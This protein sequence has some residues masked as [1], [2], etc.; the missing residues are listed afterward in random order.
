MTLFRSS[1]FALTEYGGGSG[2]CRKREPAR[3]GSACPVRR[4]GVANLRCTL[5][6]DAMR[7]V[8]LAAF[9]TFAFVS[10][11]SAQERWSGFYLGGHGGYGWGNSSTSSD[12]DVFNEDVFS[13]GAGSISSDP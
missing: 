9:V 7:R 11:A 5:A 3:N 1:V 4:P 10:Q 8:L 6:L 13:F 2:G 12:D